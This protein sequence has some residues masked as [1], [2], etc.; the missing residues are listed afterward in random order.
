MIRD[1]TFSISQKP[2][3]ISDVDMV[4]DILTKAVEKAKSA[5]IRDFMMNVHS[6]LRTQLEARLCTAIGSSSR[7]MGRLLERL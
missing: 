4:A 6:T 1:A 2:Y 3:R 5:K 7:M